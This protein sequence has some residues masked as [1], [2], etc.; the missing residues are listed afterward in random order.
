VGRTFTSNEAEAAEALV[1]ASHTFASARFADPSAALGRVLVLDGESFEVIGVM[2]PDFAYPGADIQLWLPPP[3][4]TT[5]DAEA[6]GRGTGSWRVLGRLRA[7]VTLEA[8]RADLR[9]VAAAL[10]DEHPENSGLGIRAVPLQEQQAG[11]SRRVALRMLF[12]AVAL[13]LL[14]ACAN[15]GHLML[16]RSIDR[17]GDRAIRTALGASRMRLARQALAEN[18]LIALLAGLLGAA[19]ATAGVELLASV[20]SVDVIGPDVGVGAPALV[21]VAGLSALIG[22]AF[23][24]APLLRRTAPAPDLM[25]YRVISSGAG[26]RRARR[27]LIAAQIGL[28]LILVFSASLLLRSLFASAAV[29]PGFDP[30]GVLWA[31]LSVPEPEDRLAFYEGAVESVSSLEGVEAAG[32]IEDLFISGAPNVQIT[33]EASSIQRTT[34]MPLRIDAIAGDFFGAIGAPLVAGR[35]FTSADRADSPPVA[36][37]NETMARRLW[38]GESALGRRFHSGDASSGA[39][40]VEVVG[41]V[42]DMRRQGLELEPIAQ[43]FRPYAQAPSRNMNLLMRSEIAPAA[44]T[45]VLRQRLAAVD[46]TVPLYGVTTV[47]QGMDRYVAPRRLQTFLLGVFS[48]VALILAAVGVYGVLHYS[49]SKRSQEIGI[50]VAVGARPGDVVRMILREGLM[51]AIPGIALGLLGALWVSEW[52]TA[53]LFEVSAS[54]PWSITSTGITLLGATLL[55]SYLPARRAAAVD[56]NAALRGD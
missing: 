46:P 51:L 11:A 34:R 33:V 3:H 55:A 24:V 38:P 9:S 45:P 49:V 31:N 37:V 22:T 5:W 42:G 10:E 14:I 25:G 20:A 56:P 27:A 41:V 28:A 15:A 18:L 2:P 23:G 6:A 48:T 35:L 36:I 4:F 30:D 32:I 29:D 7:G 12:G 26:S 17:A 1:V 39:S 44:L 43:V 50:R 19:V 52:L 40:T 53:L 21:Y 16:T 47:A 54:D 8:A 13:V